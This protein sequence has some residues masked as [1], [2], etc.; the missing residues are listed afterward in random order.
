MNMDSVNGY[1]YGL[2]PLVVMEAGFFILF[3]LG[4]TQPRTK[5]DWRSFGGFAAFIVALFTEMYGFPFTVFLLSG[6]LINRYPGF[7]IYGH[8]AG[9]L[10]NTIFGWKGDP[11]AD[12][13][14]VVSDFVIL[15]GLI[16]IG[17]AWA[18]L[19][20][21]QSSHQVATTGL[22]RWVR[23]PQYIGFSLI[24]VGFIM[25]W[26]TIPTLVMFPVLI[27]MYVRLARREEKDALEEFGEDYQRYRDVTP[28]FLP[29]LSFN[30]PIPPTE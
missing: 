12:F 25:Q 14:H 23:H 5:R 17:A 6:W 20:R 22:Y 3:T 28:A 30:S 15:F 11:H 19:Y 21:A 9:H 13:L 24:M 29:R 4:F 8:D 26:P 27:W 10:W 7:N 18:V 16:I 1:A 2:W